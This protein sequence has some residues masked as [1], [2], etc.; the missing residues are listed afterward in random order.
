M[1]K[2]NGAYRP[3][4]SKEGKIIIIGFIALAI[5][6]IWVFAFDGDKVIGGEG[7]SN[8]NTKKIETPI[9]NMKNLIHKEEAEKTVIPKTTETP[10]SKTETPVSKDKT[11]IHEE[12]KVVQIDN[13]QTE[14]LLREIQEL[15][16]L[17]EDYQTEMS[18][19]S[20]EIV[21][22]KQKPVPKISDYSSKISEFETRITEIENQPAPKIP[23]HS[24]Q[25]EKLE[26]QIDSL[27]S[28]ISLLK[29]QQSEELKPQPNPEAEKE[30]T[31]EEKARDLRKK[32][33]KFLKK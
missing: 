20:S 9:E 16:N 6:I 28:E 11:T 8:K 4:K 24:S 27:N 18:Q 30:K 13:E 26:A 14:K 33:D 19:L 32:I 12:Q 1:S 7:P 25:I 23:N 22:I 29:K 5:F 10:I 2:N 15:K 31:W 17:L 21:K 3:P